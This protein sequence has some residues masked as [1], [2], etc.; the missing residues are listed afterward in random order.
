[1]GK[2]VTAPLAQGYGALEFAS[3]LDQ[4]KHASFVLVPQYTDWTVQDVCARRTAKAACP[5]ILMNTKNR[6]PT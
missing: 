2:E 3:D 1:M 4:Q 5:A 6:I